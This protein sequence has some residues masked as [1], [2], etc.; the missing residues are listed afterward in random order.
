[1]PCPM[2]RR[3]SRHW[4]RVPPQNPLERFWTG[5]SHATDR[6]FTLTELSVLF[7]VSARA[8]VAQSVEQRP[9]KPRVGSSILPLGTIIT[10]NM[11]LPSFSILFPA[12]RDSQQCIHNGHRN[13]RATLGTMRRYPGNLVLY[14]EKF[15][16]L[17]SAYK[18]DRNTNDQ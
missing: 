2:I 4:I 9:E 15:L 1:M 10:S 11:F 8:E 18:P 6:D 17:R 12:V 16:G 14:R 7:I 13:S 5:T 3:L